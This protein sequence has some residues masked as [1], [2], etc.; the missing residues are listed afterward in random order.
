MTTLINEKRFFEQVAPFLFNNGDMLPEMIENAIRAKATMVKIS[1]ENELLVI[2][3]NGKV[4]E[5]LSS[6]F[7]VAQSNYDDDVEKAQKP[8]G[9]GILSLISNA[10]EVT[11]ES[12]YNSIKIDGKKYFND[13]NYRSTLLNSIEK[14]EKHFNGMKITVLLKKAID[15]MIL[16]KLNEL[17]AYYDIDITFNDIA[18]K[19]KTKIEA[20]FE[21]EISKGVIALV[22]MKSLSNHWAGNTDGYVIWH[23]KLIN[24]PQIK[25]FTI[26][27]NGKTDLVTPTLPDRKGITLDNER[28]KELSV[29]IEN[30]LKNEIQSFIN[31]HE[32][33]NAIEKVLTMLSGSYNLD[34]LSNY[35]ECRRSDESMKYFDNNKG[36]EVYINGVLDG[37]EYFSLLD[38]CLESSSFK[39][40]NLKLGNSNAPKWVLDRVQDRCIFEVEISEKA[41][42]ANKYYVYRDDFVIVDS[43]ILNGKKI[44]AVESNYNE[45]I[46][47]TTEFDY[48]EFASKNCEKYCYDEQSYNEAQNEILED[49][50]SIINVYKDNITI[51]MD[52]KFNHAIRNIVD[53]KSIKKEDISK[54]EIIKNENGKWMLSVYHKEVK[55]DETFEIF[56]IFNELNI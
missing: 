39:F 1:T 5:D 19:T 28:G 41:T 10:I 17:F 30:L 46:Y 53:A 33:F 32:N 43:I 22:P 42:Y 44:S 2:E 3:N 24:A 7:I 14:S 4:L 26:I 29:K 11:F 51:D 45:T 50:E 49:F 6:L 13:E 52:Y 16:Y 48:S 40:V 15:G 21:K 54:F 55:L 34:K 27:V 9:M 38:E 56:N 35:Y 18:I 47:F 37:D 8:A 31:E 23:G 20:L 12:G 25:P 36:V